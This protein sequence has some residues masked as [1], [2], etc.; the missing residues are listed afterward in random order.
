M[1]IQDILNETDGVATGLIRP[2]VAPNV[3]STKNADKLPKA[4]PKK[5]KS[6]Y[7]VGPGGGGR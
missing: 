7:G 3:Y 2:K 6:V 1:K 4:P 5:G